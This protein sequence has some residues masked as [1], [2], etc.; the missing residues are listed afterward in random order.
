MGQRYRL[1][2]IA[3][4]TGS[5]L[6]ETLGAIE[7]SAELVAALA[8]TVIE[9]A[10]AD[11]T[12]ESVT[13]EQVATGATGPEQPKRKR[14]TKAEIAADK[15]AAEQGTAPVAPA[16]PAPAVESV[17]APAPAPAPVAAPVAPAAPV[18]AAPAPPY[19]PFAAK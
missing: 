12:G 7:G 19:D 13:V 11:E 17:P 15:L 5:E 1:E 18:S 8:P 16:A 10:L 14:R 2:V 9:T 3:I 6:D 4:G